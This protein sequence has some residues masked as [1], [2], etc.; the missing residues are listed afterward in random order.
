MRHLFSPSHVD[1]SEGRYW[2]DLVFMALAYCC[3][4]LVPSWV[5][6]ECHC[7]QLDAVIS[8]SGE[9]TKQTI[10][11][12]G[13]PPWRYRQVLFNPQL[14][15]QPAAL[16]QHHSEGTYRVH[17]TGH[18]PLFLLVNNHLHHLSIIIL[19]SCCWELNFS[20]TT[21]GLKGLLW[22]TCCGEGL[23]HRLY[24]LLKVNLVTMVGLAT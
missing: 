4:W 6:T 15:W 1:A 21:I 11:L 12:Y 24:T 3:W 19:H 7:R 2:R 17:R 16:G 5:S 13:C 9:G 14:R 18:H 8:L 20:C 22:I 23:T 10:V